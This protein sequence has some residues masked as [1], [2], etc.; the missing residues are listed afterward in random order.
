[1]SDT[2]S[3][4]DGELE[5]R[6]TFEARM[7]ELDQILGAVA[8]DYPPDD[9]RARAE[10][11]ATTVIEEAARLQRLRQLDQR[12]LAERAVEVLDVARR[13]I[14][15][16]RI[17]EGWTQKELAEHMRRN[18]FTNW[19]RITVAESESG[20]RR[21]TF[22]ELLTLADTFGSSVAGLLGAFEG[23]EVCRLN[24]STVIDVESARRLLG[25]PGERF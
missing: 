19:Q 5:R 24:D 12:S 17:E 21:L 16:H 23:G 18:G 20:R 8:G 10:E 13:A 4:E 7:A 25:G 11:L 15:A 2:P 1:M 14:R 6:R 3:I 9:W 22:E